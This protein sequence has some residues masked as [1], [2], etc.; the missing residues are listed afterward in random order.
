MT[1]KVIER[2]SDLL[3]N[4]TAFIEM[5]SPFIN[6]LN[7]FRE[8][9]MPDSLFKRLEHLIE[10]L[11]RL[12]NHAKDRRKPLQLQMQ[13][14]TAIK[15]LTPKFDGDGHS[16]KSD[17]KTMQQQHQKLRSLHK[18]ELRG[19]LRELRRDNQYLAAQQ[20]R[21]IK[22]KDAAYKSKIRKIE[23]MLAHDQGEANK[24]EREKKKLKKR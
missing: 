9:K 2:Y 3:A 23:G 13:R 20:T 7:D 24:M 22:A 14:P 15:L 17:Y 12:V 5:F 4:S 8:V 11:I 1:C 16:F 18:K 6:L 10:K 21:E 19:A